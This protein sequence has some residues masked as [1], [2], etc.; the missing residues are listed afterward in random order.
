MP[1]HAER[2]DANCATFPERCGALPQQPPSAYLKRLYYDSLVFTPEA[3]RRL[4]DTVGAGQVLLG[5]DHPYPW[6]S[7]A[8]DHI[9]SVPGLSEAERRAMLGE[10]A[11]HLLGIERQP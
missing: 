11:A 7:T 1:F 2:L 5:T 4:V 6:T 10:T 3:L 9:L 8:V